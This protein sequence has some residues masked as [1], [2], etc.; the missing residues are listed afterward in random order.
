MKKYKN[1][2]FDM[3]N[4][5]LDF[6]PHLITS[7]YTQDTDIIHKLVKEIFFKQEWLDMDQGIMSEEEAYHQIIQRVEPEYHFIVKDILDHWHESLIEREIMSDLLEQLKQKGYK[8]YLFSNA[9]LRFNAYKERIKALNYFEYKVMSAEILYS[10]PSLEFYRKGFE[11]C[12]IN[13]EESFF[14]D[15]SAQN[16]LSAND[17]GMD[18]YIY[19][20]SYSLLIDYLKQMSI[21]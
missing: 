3:G 11:L 8:L 19:N 21:L 5:L 2:I 10:K 7:K 16:I 12:N 15:D 9:S 17:L 20:G 18:G 4:V 1:I 14:I 13:P 6:S